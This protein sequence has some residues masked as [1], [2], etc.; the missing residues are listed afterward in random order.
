MLSPCV[1]TERY[2]QL[3]NRQQSSEEK[4]GDKEKKRSEETE[5]RKEIRR[6]KVE[7]SGL[8]GDKRNDG[9]KKENV[10]VRKERTAVSGQGKRQEENGAKAKRGKQ[11]KLKEEKLVLQ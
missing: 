11:T 7:R 6:G 1:K 4:S 2:C 9:G 3:S 8:E 10:I 5:L